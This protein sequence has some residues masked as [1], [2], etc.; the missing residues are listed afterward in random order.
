MLVRSALRAIG[1][2]TVRLQS[3]PTTILRASLYSTMNVRDPSTPVVGYGQ[4]KE[5]AIN[6]PGGS[7]SPVTPASGDLQK[8]AR[9]LNESIYSQLT[10]TLHN[11]TLQDKVAV[12]TG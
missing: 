7:I 11:F 4:R 2:P 3:T 9:P 6:I 5:Q 10:P 8:V 1:Q 12:I